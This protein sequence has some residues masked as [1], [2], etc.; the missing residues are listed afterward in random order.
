MIVGKDCPQEAPRYPG[1]WRRDNN[2]GGTNLS[3]LEYLKKQ[4]ENWVLYVKDHPEFPNTPLY[5]K[6]IYVE[7]YLSEIRDPLTWRPVNKKAAKTYLLEAELKVLGSTIES[8]PEDEQGSTEERDE[9]IDGFESHPEIESVQETMT[10][11]GD[12]DMFSEEELEDEKYSRR[13][14]EM[15]IHTFLKRS[16]TELFEMDLEI[17]EYVKNSKWFKNRL[18]EYKEEYMKEQF[19]HL[20][21]QGILEKLSQ[22]PKFIKESEEVKQKLKHLSMEEKATRTLFKCLNDTIEILSKTPGPEARNQLHVVTAAA[23]HPTHGTPGFSGSS[24]KVQTE[25]KTMKRKFLERSTDVLV[26]PTKKARNIYPEEVEKIVVDHWDL[27]TIPEPALHRQKPKPTEAN[28][29]ILPVRYQTLTDKEQ[30]ELF[31]GD[32]AEPI[33]EVMKKFSEQSI[34]MVNNWKDN[35][36]KRS[37]V[38]YYENLPEKFP[39]I[40]YFLDKKP[41]EIKPLHDHTTALCVTCEAA[42]LNW[43]TLVKT[44]KNSNQCNSRRCP[45]WICMCESVS[46]EEEHQELV[47]TECNC[48]CNCDGCQDCK[49]FLFFL[50]YT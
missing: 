47:Q 15:N 28:K 32:C 18:S 20:S 23:T 2:P 33:G 44:L 26:P 38:K 17:P 41:A 49:V 50:F 45:N 39:K 16:N 7:N 5:K 11:T 13:E 1:L 29:E 42:Q 10:T 43:Y 22:T 12:E 4:V 24:K 34:L 19:D 35:E 37:R 8:N 30:Y 40:D 21:S 27:N 9:V 25:A 6:A 31:K 36:A 46:D 3:R 14:K 48:K